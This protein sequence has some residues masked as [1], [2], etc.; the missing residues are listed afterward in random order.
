[1]SQADINGILGQARRRN[2]ET[3]ITGILFYLD[4]NFLQLLEGEDP[5]LGETYQ[6]IKGDS[7]HRNLV[8]M[9]DDT[10]TQRAFAGHDMAYRGITGPELEKNE[11]LFIRANG[12]WWL[13]DDTGVDQTLK[14]LIETFLRVNDSRGYMPLSGTS[15]R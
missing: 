1:M 8:Q 3:G 14:I 6:R 10:I 7:R 15:D 12:R 2:A 11:D 5:A 4:G 13:R 9:L